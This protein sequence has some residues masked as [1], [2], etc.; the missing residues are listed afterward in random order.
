[1]SIL[2][3]PGQA[4]DQT[5]VEAAEQFRLIPTIHDRES[6]EAMKRHATGRLPCAVKLAVGQER[7]GIP[8]ENA[9]AFIRKVSDSGT[10]SVAIVNTHPHVVEGRP[11][12]LRWQFE[13]RFGARA[14]R[15]SWC[16]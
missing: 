16:R 14:S 1:M 13:R 15:L 2:L 5:Y 3:Y 12:H 4:I 7:L 8:A 11:D 10:L 9:A 6:F